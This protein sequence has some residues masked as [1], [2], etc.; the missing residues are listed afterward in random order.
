LF[1]V[2]IAKKHQNP[3][4]LISCLFF[5]R[6]PICK[7]TVVSLFFFLPQTELIDGGV[8]ITVTIQPPLVKTRQEAEEN[9]AGNN[10]KRRRWK[11]ST[12]RPL[13]IDPEAS[14]RCY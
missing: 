13:E 4:L 3:C 10:Y 8:L 6:N 5:W 9:F 2:A 7:K 11:N 12:D 14:D 1:I